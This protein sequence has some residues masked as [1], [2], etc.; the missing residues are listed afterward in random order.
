MTI[1]HQDIGVYS[2]S[3]TLDNNTINIHRF[4]LFVLDLD[5]NTVNKICL[6]L[7]VGDFGYG[8]HKHTMFFTACL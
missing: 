3:V 7:S 2:V 1:S 8:C 4:V 6:L 5:T